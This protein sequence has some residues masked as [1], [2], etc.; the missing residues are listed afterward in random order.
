[1][2]RRVFDEQFMPVIDQETQKQI[3]ELFPQDF[4]E[5]KGEL[6]KAG[7]WRG[8]KVAVKFVFGNLH[9]LVKDPKPANSNSKMINKHRW[10]MYVASAGDKEK[11]GKFIESVKYHFHPTFKPSVI[12]ISQH[13]FILSRVGW[14]LF[15]VGIEIEFK[16]WT[17]LKKMKLEHDLLFEE[18][19]KQEGFIIELEKEEPSDDVAAA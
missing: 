7:L 2:C 13:P 14:G 9:S 18:K 10:V 1:M 6:M 8:N 3:I 4:E 19:G 12:K 5:R 17:G 11:T 16:K 15:T